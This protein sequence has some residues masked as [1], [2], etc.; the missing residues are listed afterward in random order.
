MRTRY[1]PEENSMDVRNLTF[2]FYGFLA[3]WLI[4]IVYVISIAARERKL[5]QELDRVKRLVEERDREP[6]TST[7]HS[8]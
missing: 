2:L 6:K 3:A 4:V 7:S 8:V 5:R 1:D